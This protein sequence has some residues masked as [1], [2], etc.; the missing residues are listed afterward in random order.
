MT[1]N[2]ERFN[3]PGLPT[4][5]GHYVHATR[6]NELIFVSGQLP[7]VSGASGSSFEDQ[8]RSAISAVF[9]ALE[10]AGSG[11]DLALK[12]NAYIVGVEH[13]PEFNAVFA[14]MF[15]D[16]RPAR[17]V[18]PVPELHH[19]LLVEVEAIAIRRT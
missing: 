4:P 18:I 7:H 8:T 2:V 14:E 13:W 15:G 3:S 6:S 19:G 16:H 9:Q 11:P 17:A 1:S 12:V 5:A 10:V